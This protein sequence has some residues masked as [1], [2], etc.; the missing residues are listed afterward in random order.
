MGS[1]GKGN[2]KVIWSG[3]GIIMSLAV[4]PNGQVVEAKVGRIGGFFLRPVWQ[5]S[6]WRRGRA[7]QGWWRLCWWRQLVENGDCAS[8]LLPDQHNTSN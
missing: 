7:G 3:V 4:R 6:R 8:S 1:F 5:M 2:A